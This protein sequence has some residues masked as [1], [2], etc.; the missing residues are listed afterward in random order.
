MGLRQPDMQRHDP[1]LHPEPEQEQQKR[2]VAPRRR[3]APAESPKALETEIPRGLEQQQKTQ[4]QTAR[5]DV[6]HDEEEHAGIPRFGLLMLEADQA[7]SRQRHN[8]PGHE[9]EERIGRTEHQRYGQQQGVMQ[10]AQDANVLASVK[11]PRVAERINGHRHRQQRHDEH[12]ESAQRVELDGELHIG[13]GAGPELKCRRAGRARGQP[14]HGRPD[15]AQAAQGCAA[16]A[17]AVGGFLAP[18]SGQAA[19]DTSGVGEQCN[20]EQELRHPWR[21]LIFSS[22]ARMASAS[23]AARN[24]SSI[25]VCRPNR[26][27]L[28]SRFK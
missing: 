8:L 7:V 20:L 6:R 17:D 15:A 11:A 14:Q 21:I 4:H 10:R 25:S 9:E 3:Q 22:T 28:A 13:N 24:W 18:K 12:E 5:A 26:A 2:R 16:E 19:H 1:R 27:R 23:P